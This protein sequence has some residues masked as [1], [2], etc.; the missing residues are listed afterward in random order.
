MSSYLLLPQMI[1]RSW[2][3]GNIQIL[4]AL[5]DTGCELL[6]I[7]REMNVMGI[8]H[9]CGGIWRQDSKQIAGTVLLITY[10]MIVVILSVLH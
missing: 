6:L 10:A 4:P 7:T 1:L 5:S 9:E 3:K 2:R 8:V